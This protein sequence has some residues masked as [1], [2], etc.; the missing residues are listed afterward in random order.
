VSYPPAYS[1]QWAA[2]FLTDIG[3]PVTSENIKF[4]NAWALQE[5]GGGK[6]NPLNTT[7]PG[8]GGTNAVWASKAN[9]AGVKDYPTVDAGIQA[10]VK[11]IT[12]G[13]YN[14]IL[15]GLKSGT[16][17]LATAQGARSLNTWGT[18]QAA[19]VKKLGGNLPTP[20]AASPGS[21]GSQIGASGGTAKD[22][23][24]KIHFPVAGD[25][26]LDPVLWVAMVLV[27]TG[28]FLVGGALI[29]VGAGSGKTASAGSAVL[30]AVP[31]AIVAK[32]AVKA[33]A[34][35]DAAKSAAEA[36]PKTP[37]KVGAE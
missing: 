33:T 36:A 7:Q 18:G 28:T 22:C 29:A 13:K 35:A 12:N 25:V 30:N 24:W 11:T 37:A 6:N 16:S 23:Y 4:M 31:G 3:A 8:Y 17:A 26:C 34:A 15:A 32:R 21:A 14:D 1:Q 5:G 19:V 20:D 10:T 2:T 9:T 27:G